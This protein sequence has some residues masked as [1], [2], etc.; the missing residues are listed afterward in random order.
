M[1]LFERRNEHGPLPEQF[2]RFAVETEEHTRLLV[3]DDSDG[4]HSV[5]PNNRR[6][7]AKARQGGR[8]SDV[9]GARP[10]DGN[11][12]LQAGAIEPRAAPDRP[13]FGLREAGQDEGQQS[14]GTEFHADAADDFNTIGAEQDFTLGGKRW[15]AFLHKPGRADLLVGLDARQ[16]VP[17]GLVVSMRDLAIE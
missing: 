15:P 3:R 13:V 14:E 17:T 6:G 12:L 2:A 7:V 11:V 9:A 1:L 5:T 16:R 8:P 4:E 10:V